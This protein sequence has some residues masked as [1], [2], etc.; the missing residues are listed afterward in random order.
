MNDPA[1]ENNELSQ[2][3]ALNSIVDMLSLDQLWVQYKDMV[4][5]KVYH[6]GDM[7]SDWLEAEAKEGKYIL[8]ARRQMFVVVMEARDLMKET[9]WNNSSF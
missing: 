3:R 7:T 9:K 2:Y 8:H 5:D 4:P 6:K 1:F